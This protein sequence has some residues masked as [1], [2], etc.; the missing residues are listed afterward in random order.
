MIQATKAG[1]SNSSL[2]NKVEPSAISESSE[3]FHDGLTTENRGPS[4]NELNNFLSEV[5]MR[6]AMAVNGCLPEI[7]ASRRIVEH[8]NRNSLKGFDDVGYFIMDGVKV[9]EEGKT[10]EAKKRDSLTMEEKNFG[11]KR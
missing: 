9:F 5:A 1:T 6:R 7:E 8:F 4:Q 3:V 11:G 10:E 2:K